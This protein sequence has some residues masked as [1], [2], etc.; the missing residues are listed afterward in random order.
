MSS[1]KDGAEERALAH[2]DGLES[3]GTS[4]SLRYHH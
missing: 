2:I 4:D 1:W 3:K